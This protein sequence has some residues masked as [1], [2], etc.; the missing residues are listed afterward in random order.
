MELSSLYVFLFTCL[1]TGIIATGETKKESRKGR[2]LDAMLDWPY[3]SQNW[4]TSAAWQGGYHP[5]YSYFPPDRLNAISWAEQPF[6]PS[7]YPYGPVRGPAQN[8]VFYRPTASNLYYQPMG[9]I[10]GIPQNWMPVQ[11]I[12][13]PPLKYITGTTHKDTVEPGIISSPENNHHLT[14]VFDEYQPIPLVNSLSEITNDIANDDSNLASA[15]KVSHT[16][17]TENYNDLT[18]NILKNSS[19]QEV[20]LNT[21]VALNHIV[22]LVQYQ[23]GPSENS[24]FGTTTDKAIDID[25]IASSITSVTQMNSKSTTEQYGYSDV[26]VDSNIPDQGPNKAVEGTLP[27]TESTNEASPFN[28][29]TISDNEETTF[30]TESDNGFDLEDVNLSTEKPHEFTIEIN[31]D[32]VGEIVSTEFPITSS[33]VFSTLTKGETLDHNAIKDSSETSTDASFSK[34]TVPI[35]SS[36]AQTV[37]AATWSSLSDDY[38]ANNMSSLDPDMLQLNDSTS[39]VT[40]E[41]GIKCS[42][43]AKLRKAMVKFLREMDYRIQVLVAESNCGPSFAS[44]TSNMSFL[45]KMNEMTPVDLFKKIKLQCYFGC[46]IGSETF[47]FR[48]FKFEQSEEVQHLLSLPENMSCGTR[49]TDVARIK[50]GENARDGQYPWMAAVFIHYYDPEF[51]SFVLLYCGGSIISPFHILT[52]AHCLSSIK[53]HPN[54]FVHAGSVSLPF[55]NISATLENIDRE[56][57]AEDE[58]DLNPLELI[59]DILKQLSDPKIIEKPGVLRFVSDLL[60]ANMDKKDGRQGRK[61]SKTVEERAKALEEALENQFPELLFAEGGSLHTDFRVDED[62]A[63]NDF[64][65]IKLKKPLEF[66]D[67]IRPICLGPPNINFENQR[68]VITGWGATTEAEGSIQLQVAS[69]PIWSLEKCKELYPISII[70]PGETSVCAGGVDPVTSV[71]ACR[72]DSGGPL[73]YQLRDGRWSVIGIVSYALNESCSYAPTVY[74]KVSS[75]IP[76]IRQTTYLELTS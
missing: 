68:G 44:V 67:Y 19:N 7:F 59:Q 55:N 13:I 34:T 39:I 24:V 62:R 12:N 61:I 53:D 49:R 14:I 20:A 50:N 56:N 47:Y 76:W 1:T 36:V 64:A 5:S 38:V 40:V 69:T 26:G 72:G 75:S 74:A 6:S 9:N 25:N 4:Q 23:P 52:A 29:I 37:A 65:I 15:V 31:S 54:V 51:S 71:T 43:K 48:D 22:N 35:S 32:E 42:S 3:F 60:S 41:V 21:E 66:N 16:S 2:Y 18:D 45:I 28:V 73:Q 63:E 8:S 58:K 10:P 70:N 17:T 33:D 27:T 30:I 57:V 46:T 11:N